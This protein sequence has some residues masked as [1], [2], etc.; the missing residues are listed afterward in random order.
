MLH[1]SINL[2]TADSFLKLSVAEAI[3]EL[4]ANFGKDSLQLDSMTEKANVLWH[5]VEEKNK[6]DSMELSTIKYWLKNH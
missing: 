1:S 2:K 3:K 5:K 4:P 6:I